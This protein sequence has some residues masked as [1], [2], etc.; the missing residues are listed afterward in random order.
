MASTV[1]SEIKAAMLLMLEELPNITAT[2]KVFGISRSALASARAKDSEFNDSIK[3]AVADGYDMMEE[4]ARRRA[5]EGVS[6][7]VYYRGEE[8][9][10]IQKFSDTLLKFLLT[11]CKPEKFNPGA[12]VTVGAGEKVSFTFNV[13]GEE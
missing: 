4:E 10:S 1:T 13:G 11:H 12:K 5:V 3:E 8:I 9:G 7:P 6:E 2:R